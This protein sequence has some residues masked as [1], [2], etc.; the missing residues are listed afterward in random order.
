MWI[1]LCSGSG[2]VDGKVAEC[3]VD[4]GETVSILPKSFRTVRVQLYYQHTSRRTSERLIKGQKLN[5]FGSTEV[6]CQ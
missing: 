5:I 2:V 3:L 6:P 4:T 1:V